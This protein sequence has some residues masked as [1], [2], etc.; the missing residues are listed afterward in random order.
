MVGRTSTP[1][2]LVRRNGSGFGA[3]EALETIDS[4]GDGTTC[5]SSGDVVTVCTLDV[6]AA[7]LVDVDNDAD[8]DIV[9][10]GSAG[11]VYRNDGSGH[12]TRAV[13]VE[14]SVTT[15]SGTSNAVLSRMA[16]L[17]VDAEGATLVAI[18]RYIDP[19]STVLLRATA[20]SLAIVAERTG[21]RGAN[22]LDVNDDVIRIC[23]D[24]TTVELTGE[25]ATSTQTYD[26]CAEAVGDIDDDGDLDV[27]SS[28]R[29]IPAVNGAL[30]LDAALRPSGFGVTWDAPLVVV[31]DNGHALAIATTVE[32]FLD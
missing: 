9:A 2:A 21:Q 19:Q 17:S 25:F 14:L 16:P 3:P 22:V 13:A 15:A 29:F 24:N 23:D 30:D 32:V 10:V 12:F 6:S 4:L 8:L 5:E 1:V 27:V 26:V 20:T 28:T 11:R 18:N 31:G 7:A